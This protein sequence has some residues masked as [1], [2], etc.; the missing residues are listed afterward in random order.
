MAKIE[1]TQV[2]KNWTE[3]YVV[4]PYRHIGGKLET[5]IECLQITWDGDLVSKTD[6]DYY[7]KKGLIVSYDGFNIIS[8]KG[9]EYLSEL[10]IIHC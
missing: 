1:K 7:K 5:L 9:I 8:A 2:K 4:D 6:R 10:G 3:K